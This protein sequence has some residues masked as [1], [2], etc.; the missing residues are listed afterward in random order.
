MLRVK[1]VTSGRF[2][3]F[4][5]FSIHNSMLQNQVERNQLLRKSALELDFFPLIQKISKFSWHALL[6]WGTFTFIRYAVCVDE[7]CTVRATSFNFS[8]WAVNI[9][10]KTKAPQQHPYLPNLRR[11]REL[12]FR[13]KLF[14]RCSTEVAKPSEIYSSEAAKE[15]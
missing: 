7:T 8:P 5:G 11:H 10:P 1:N 2:I 15:E 12:V 6:Q 3:H 13:G 14:E 9:D 4:C